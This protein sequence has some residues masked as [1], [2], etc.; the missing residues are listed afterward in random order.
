MRGTCAVML[1]VVAQFSGRR[2]YLSLTASCCLCI[3]TNR[4]SVYTEVCACHCVRINA[5]CVLQPVNQPVKRIVRKYVCF[6]ASCFESSR[7]MTLPFVSSKDTQLNVAVEWF[8]LLIHLRGFPCWLS[9][10]TGFAV[11]PGFLVSA[12]FNCQRFDSL[13]S[14]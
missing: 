12:L 6:L 8:V 11:S 3:F 4:Q 1:G 5:V 13:F 7:Y 14:I 2:Q 9:H 10:R